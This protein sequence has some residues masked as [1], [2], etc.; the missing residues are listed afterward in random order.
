M[1]FYIAHLVLSAIAID[2]KQQW[3][4]WYFTAQCDINPWSRVSWWLHTLHILLTTT[5]LPIDYIGV[6]AARS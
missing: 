3:L 6:Y 4:L 5:L 1:F 2:N